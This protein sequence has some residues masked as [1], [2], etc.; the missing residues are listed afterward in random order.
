MRCNLALCLSL[1]LAGCA[2]GSCLHD[3]EIGRVMSV[4]RDANQQQQMVKL[5]LKNRAVRICLI[6]SLWANAMEPGDVLQG[7][8]SERFNVDRR[9]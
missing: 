2:D 3:G 1:L 8:I 9:Q 6:S 5:R 7:P 4:T